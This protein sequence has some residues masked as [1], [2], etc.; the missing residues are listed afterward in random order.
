[1]TDHS[2]RTN[3]SYSEIQHLTL[4]K[5]LFDINEVSRKNIEPANWTAVIPAAGAGSRLGY[6]LPKVLY[7]LLDRPILEWV[8]DAV[9][10]TVSNFIFVLSP[11]GKVLVEPLLEKLLGEKADIVVQEKPTGMGDA[12]LL[13]EEK[14]QT[15]N[16][17]IVW[18]DQVMLNAHTV[19]V[20]A[21]LHEAY[22][23]ANLTFPTIIKRKPYIHIERNADLKIKRVLQY[24]ENE[25]NFEFGESDCGLFLFSTNILFKTL[26]EA[27][28]DP[29]SI[30]M[31][32]G[33]FNLLQT[34]PHFETN[35]GSVKTVRIDDELECLGV[36]TPEE[37][38]YAENELVK[39]HKR[40]LG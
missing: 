20:C 19:E 38:K 31:S 1:M 35:P 39:R 6:H 26:R 12:V 28:N 27:H 3:G 21:T 8:V 5:C 36:N 9:R 33:E 32:T 14:V 4:M 34:L 24:R 29:S 37:A 13:A 11:E 23:V 18:G 2:K 7:P 25:I 40:L 10:T 30:G 16:C 15:P 17:L 22:P